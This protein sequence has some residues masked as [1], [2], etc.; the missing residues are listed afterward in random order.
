MISKQEDILK[1]VAFILGCGVKAN[2]KA[3]QIL[4]YL[5]SQG[6]AI[7]ADGDLSEIKQF[8]G[9]TRRILIQ[10]GYTKVE[11]LI[12]EQKLKEMLRGRRT[13]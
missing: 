6:V 8:K 11:P 3:H 4:S 13:E 1:G 5:H 10:A 2:I 12:A 7:K 9:Q